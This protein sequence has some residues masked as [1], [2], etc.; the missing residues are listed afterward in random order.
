[1][2]QSTIKLITNEELR[3]L[4]GMQT[5]SGLSKLRA[6]DATFP[7]PIK[8][9]PSRQARPKFDVAEVEQWLR[10]KKAE[11]DGKSVA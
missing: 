10:D 9:S 6:R 11:R 3:Q 2:E 1:M 7:K 8:M 5:V 4:L